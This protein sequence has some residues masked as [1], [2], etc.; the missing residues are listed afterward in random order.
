MQRM[1]ERVFWETIR[2]AILAVIAEMKR[3]QTESRPVDLEKM[4]RAG[5]TVTDAIRDRYI[6]PGPSAA[7][8]ETT[9]S[10]E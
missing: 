10:N 7:A 8:A 2:R 3:A 1:S 6:R 4:I 5:Y 9:Q